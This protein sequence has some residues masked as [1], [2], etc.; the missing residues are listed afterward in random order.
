[1]KTFN[2][3]LERLLVKIKKERKYA[4]I[5]GDFNAN[6]ILENNNSKSVKDFINMFSSYY[7]HKLINMPTRERNRNY[8]LLD[9]IYTN[10]PDCYNT[11]T[12]GVLK[13]LTQSDHYPIFTIRNKIE[14]P[15]PKIH[16]RRN[17]SNKNIALFR[18]Q[19]KRNDW[20]SL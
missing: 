9:N 2:I 1:M 10:I 17:H 13:F 8:S 3:E 6:T 18:K 5:M 14:Q 19:I 4:F 20:D 12:S 16:K 11:C 7:Y 15:K